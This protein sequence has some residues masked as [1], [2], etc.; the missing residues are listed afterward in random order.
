MYMSL[1]SPEEGPKANQIDSNN[2]QS[3]VENFSQ[4]E[5]NRTK[6][7]GSSGVSIK[8]YPPDFFLT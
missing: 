4:W 5:F 7:P 2:G 8:N 6:S 1:A 3:R